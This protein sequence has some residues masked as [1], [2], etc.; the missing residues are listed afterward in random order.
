MEINN[1]PYNLFEMFKRDTK[2]FLIKKIKAHE[3]DLT[4]A[5]ANRLVADIEFSSIDNVLEW[6]SPL[7]YLLDENTIF[8]LN[9]L[10]MKILN[11]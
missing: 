11:P 1:N 7:T 8:E 10:W 5:E 4:V 6:A 2:E 3:I 9:L